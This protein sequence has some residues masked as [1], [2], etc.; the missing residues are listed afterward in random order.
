MENIVFDIVYIEDDTEEY[1]K[2]L[3]NYLKISNVA[4]VFVY[5]SYIL[6]FIAFITGMVYSSINE[7]KYY[8]FILIIL[9]PILINLY[10]RYTKKYYNSNVIG[11]YNKIIR[12][13]QKLEI[14]T[15]QIVIDTDDSKYIYKANWIKYII[16]YNNNFAIASA[17]FTGIIIPK[18]YLDEIIKQKIIKMFPDI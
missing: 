11:K 10:D 3:Q 12:N 8:N 15:N 4:K 18:R 13:H 9:I 7:L 1:F 16:E 14:H 17:D 5:L 2:A 6:A